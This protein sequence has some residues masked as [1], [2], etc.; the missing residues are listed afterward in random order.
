MGELAAG[1]RA[2][3]DYGS[4]HTQEYVIFEPSNLEREGLIRLDRAEKLFEE[5]NKNTPIPVYFML[6][7]GHQ[8][9]PDV[10]GQDSDPYAWLEKFGKYSPIIHIQQTDG[11]ADRHW[12][13]TQ[14]YNK[15][16]VPLDH[17]RP[18]QRKSTTSPKK[19]LNLSRS[20]QRLRVFYCIVHQA[21]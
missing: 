9:S 12:P 10:S 2:F 3:A 15:Q 17:F 16:G 5:F 4:Q 7:V 6:N 8:C 13:F 19:L 11:K 18:P 1:M 21:H 14:E 20:P